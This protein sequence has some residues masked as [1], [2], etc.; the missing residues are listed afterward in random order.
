M[1]DLAIGQCYRNIDNVIANLTTFVNEQID[2]NWNKSDIVFEILEM[3]LFWIYSKKFW[4]VEFKSWTNKYSS[5]K[6][7][8][9]IFIKYPG[10]FLLMYQN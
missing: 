4:M 10:V 8:R 2:F 6:L 5:S 9:E 3:G 1:A 7:S